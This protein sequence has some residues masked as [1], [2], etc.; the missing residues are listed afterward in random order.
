MT[1]TL[2]IDLDD[3]L[4][5]NPFDRFMP[6][7]LKILSE[8]LAPFVNP[9]VMVPRLLAATEQ[10][11]KNL[12]PVQTLEATFDANFYPHL[13]LTKTVIEPHLTDFYTHEFNQLRE[14]T[15]VRPEALKL[16]EQAKQNDWQIVVA[17]NPLFP[18]IAMETRLAWA[19]FSRDNSPFTFVTA[20]ESMH[21]AKPN[22]AYYAEILGRSGWPLQAVGMIGNSL[23]EDIIPPTTLGLPAFWVDHDIALLPESIDSRVSMGSLKDAAAWLTSLEKNNQEYKLSDSS[24]IMAVLSS[25]P[26]VL[27]A[28][29]NNMDEVSWQA[30]TPEQELSI[31]ELISHLQ[32][33]EKEINF[34]R[35]QT[36][37]H[38]DNPTLIGF[39]SD[40][41]ITLRDYQ[42][43]RNSQV[44]LD[45]SAQRQ[46]L[47]S[48]LTGLPSDQWKRP[49][50]HT[51]FGPTNLEEIARFIAHHDMDHIRQVFRLVFKK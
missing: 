35:I 3:T 11:I 38:E 36:I 40:I 47:L 32:D 9:E 51:I 29:I 39:D 1:K 28:L 24:A 18:L 21:F 26:A 22:P 10:M 44:L 4:L 5:L 6:A 30:K 49:A 37:L 19:G 13:G 31:L 46:Q 8:K 7:Y 41:W 25:T 12:S 42:N 15:S 23:K 43:T 20:F 27:N 34:P 48:L 16:I 33:V 2:L 50:Q 17:T 45:F 14:V